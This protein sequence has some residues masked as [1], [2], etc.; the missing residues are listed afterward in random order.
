LRSQ[1]EAHHRQ[2]DR[3]FDQ[4]PD[5]GCERRTRLKAKESDRGADRQLEEIRGTDKRGRASDIVR[6]AERA[7]EGVGDDGVE[8]ARVCVRGEMS[9]ET[10]RQVIELLR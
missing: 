4:N 3:H 6:R 10:L 2:H 8:I 9:S 5:H 1:H 7:V